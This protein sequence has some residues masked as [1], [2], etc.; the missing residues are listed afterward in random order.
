MSVERVFH[1]DER[2]CERHVRTIGTRPPMFI[3]VAEGADHELH[4]C[5]WDCL[6]RHAAEKPPAEVIP[7]EAP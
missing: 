6:L 1:C 2:G 7:T 4:F 5:G 3:T